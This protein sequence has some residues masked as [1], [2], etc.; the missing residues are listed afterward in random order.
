MKEIHSLIDL[1]FGEL[2]EDLTGLLRIRSVFEEHE[3]TEEHP[4]GL[5]VTAALERF[6]EIAARMGFRTKNIDNIVMA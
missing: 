2:L 5:S 1:D 6:L 4:F 3:R